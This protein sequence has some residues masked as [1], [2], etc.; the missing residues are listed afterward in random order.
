MPQ[1]LLNLHTFSILQQQHQQ[2]QQQQF[3]SP[4]ITPSSSSPPPTS[5]TLPAPASPPQDTTHTPSKRRKC[6]TVKQRTIL[7]ALFEQDKSPDSDTLR[8]I[9]GKVG[10]TLRQVQYWFQNKRAALR[11]LRISQGQVVDF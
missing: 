11:R 5:V 9:T 4:T 1:L 7:M 3:Q 6:L 8:G 2:Q 10:M